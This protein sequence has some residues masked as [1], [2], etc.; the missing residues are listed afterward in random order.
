MRILFARP[1]L[2]R[3]PLQRV[4]LGIGVVAVVGIA[5]VGAVVGVVLLTLGAL[6][7]FG[8]RGLRAALAPRVAAPRSSQ[9]I[10]GEYHVVARGPARTLPRAG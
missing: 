4:L 8:Y 2:Q 10:D 1:G 3:R 6:A 7:H 9:V 5:A